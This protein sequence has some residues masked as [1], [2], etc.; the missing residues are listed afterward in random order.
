MNTIE[1][2]L[3]NYIDG[4]CTAEER[5]AISILIERDEVYRHKYEE[6]LLLNAEFSNMEM[7][8]PSMAFAYNVMETIRTENAMKPLKATVDQRIIKGIGLFF[9]LT[10]SALLIFTLSQ[11]KWTSGG[12]VLPTVDINFKMPNIKEYFNSTAVYAFL[13]VDLIL[14]L[15]LLDN[16]LRKKLTNVAQQ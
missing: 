16:Y 13:F 2:K 1:E 7:D 5:E 11:I 6:L 9:I 12:S 10:I 8:E 15:F 3:W 14:G 4:T